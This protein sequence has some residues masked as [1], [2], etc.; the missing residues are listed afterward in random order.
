MPSIIETQQSEHD[1]SLSA[2]KQL[3]PDDENEQLPEYA[4]EYEIE[5][6]SIKSTPNAEMLKIQEE[7]L[8]LK[9]QQLKLQKMKKEKT[10]QSS[11]KRTAGV[12]ESKN[13]D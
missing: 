9:I 4:N 1:Q 6:S 12:L 3:A 7:I 13:I 10:R 11:K 8:E 5:Q 2:K